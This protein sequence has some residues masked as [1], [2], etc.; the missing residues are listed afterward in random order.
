M[1]RVLVTEEIEVVDPHGGDGDLAG[2]RCIV[3]RLD[4]ASSR[5]SGR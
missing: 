5:D 3:R 2:G 1:A 4:A